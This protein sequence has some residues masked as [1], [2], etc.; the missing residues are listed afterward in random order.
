[1]PGGGLDG[2]VTKVSAN[3]S[4][5]L[6]STYLAGSGEDQP[7]RIAVDGSG[8]AVYVSG[9][10]ASANFPVAGAVQPAFGG[11]PYD[12]FV[13]KIA[14]TQANQPPVVTI[15]SPPAGSL[16]AVG[17]PVTFTGSF[18]DP[19]TTDTHTAQWA[20]DTIIAAGTVTESGGNGSVSTNYA[21]TVPGVY[22]VTL[23]V[24]DQA[25]GVGQANTV[26]GLAAFIVV[27]DPNG[28]YVTG[29][30]W[31]DSPAGAY[32]ANPSLTGKATFGFVA[33][34]Q[35]GATV[36][37]GQTEF[38]FKAGNL[39]FHSSTY[40]WLVVAGARAQF[41]GTGTING[42]GTYDF[43]LT[44]IDGQVS[45]GGSV[46]RFRIKITGPGG[47]V[48]D[49]QLNAPEGADPTTALGGGSIVIHKE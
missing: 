19:N 37:S 12:A 20:F 6:F 41:K 31:I 27:Y 40:Q 21:F 26:G 13:V 22:N 46:D 49:N 29:G 3:G 11:G 23:T 1:V 18:T 44:A 33:K 32:T 25:G 16:H 10:T 24:T 28:G 34:Y 30:G 5:L 38:Q 17:T 15:T 9:Y 35:Q 39:N 43:L 45:G 36:P 4:M 47:L 8:S 2:F 7:W 42:S 14:D 48:Y